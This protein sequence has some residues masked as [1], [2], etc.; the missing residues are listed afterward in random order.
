MSQGLAVEFSLPQLF[1]PLL[2]KLCYCVKRKERV[3]DKR[4]GEPD[5]TGLG[6]EDEGL[7]LLEKEFGTQDF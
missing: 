6:S 4:E 5:S 3:R 2:L 1:L 7:V